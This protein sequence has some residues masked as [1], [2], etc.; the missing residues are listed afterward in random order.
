MIVPELPSWINIGN[1]ASGATI[2]QSFLGHF[3]ILSPLAPGVPNEFFRD[4]KYVQEALRQYQT[5][6]YQMCLAIVKSGREGQRAVLNW[7]GEVLATNLK[8]KVPHVDPTTIASDGFM[9]NV[10]AVLNK[11]A[12]PFVDIHCN[13]VPSHNCSALWSLTCFVLD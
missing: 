3:F 6:L 13:R 11:F 5:H 9:I 8:R 10:V 4:L 12:E 1:P 2:E 7:F